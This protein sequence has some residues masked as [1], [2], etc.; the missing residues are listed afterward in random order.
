MT[1]FA[2][3]VPPPGTRVSITPFPY[4]WSGQRPRGRYCLLFGDRVGHL[5]EPGPEFGQDL[6]QFGGLGLV[7]DLDL[8]LD[9]REEVDGDL[10]PTRS[11]TT[12]RLGIGVGPSPLIA[13]GPAGDEPLK[14]GGEFCF[15]PALLLALGLLPARRSFSAWAA[16]Q[17]VST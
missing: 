6:P 12:S 13:W 11:I 1:R 9:D 4:P 3:S 5:D 2:R 8:L 7:E 16:F 17:S 15:V 10:L 14:S